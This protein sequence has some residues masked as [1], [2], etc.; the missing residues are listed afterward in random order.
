MLWINWYKYKI[1]DISNLVIGRG[2]GGGGGGISSALTGHNNC[3]CSDGSYSSV[4][5]MGRWVCHGGSRL[6]Q[7]GSRLDQRLIFSF[8]GISSFSL[9]LT[10]LWSNDIKWWQSVH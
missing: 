2:R 3:R 8:F 1:V 7:S 9:G 4:S 6:D 5:Y 10:Y